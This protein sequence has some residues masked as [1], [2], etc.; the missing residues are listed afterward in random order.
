M[1]SIIDVYIVHDRTA[2]Y[3]MGWT[4]GLYDSRIDES[5]PFAGAVGMGSGRMPEELE[6][7]FRRGYLEAV[8]ARKSGVTCTV[9]L[10]DAPHD[11]TSV[12]A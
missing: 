4:C 9:A 11:S 2:T 8:A 5:A 7:E 3:K 10:H 12:A 6:R 1:T